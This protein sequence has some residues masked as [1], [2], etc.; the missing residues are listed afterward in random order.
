MYLIDTIPI[1][2]GVAQDT[3][4][5]FSSKPFQTGTLINAPLRSR[6]IKALVINASEAAS[7]KSALRSANHSLKKLESQRS[8]RLLSAD[9]IRAT[10]ATAEYF[11]CSPGAAMFRLIP[12]SALSQVDLLTRLRYPTRVDVSGQSDITKHSI[13]GLIH[14]PLEERY[15]L[16]RT[17]I[18]EEFVKGRSVLVVAPSIHEAA[19]L[20]AN[21][22]KGIERYTV[23]LNGSMPRTGFVSAWRQAL[24]TDHATLLI[25]T[26]AVA[27]IPRAD[28]TLTILESEADRAW[29]QPGRPHIDLRIFLELLTRERGANMILG[30]TMVRPETYYRWNEGRLIEAAKPRF[31][32]LAPGETR[33]EDMRVSLQADNQRFEV[34]GGRLRDTIATAGASSERTVLFASRRGLAPTTVCRDCGDAVV[35]GRCSAPVVL[36]EGREGHRR[37]FLCHKCG[38]VMNARRTCTRCGNWQLVTLGIGADLVEKEAARLYPDRPL[39]SLTA[40]TANTDKRAHDITTRFAASSGGIMIC[41]EMALRYLSRIDPAPERVAVVSVDSL[42]ALPDFRAG[43]RVFA[44]VLALRSLASKTFILQTRRP[45][46][47]VLAQAVAGDILGLYRNEL[48]IRKTLRYPPFAALI[49]LQMSGKEDAVRGEMNSLEKF[50]A[51]YNPIIYPGFTKVVRGKFVMN[52]LVKL[53]PDAWPKSDLIAKLRSLPPYIEVEIDPESVL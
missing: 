49:K 20:Y 52:A 32:L 48:T 4:T 35:C 13:P 27:A 22:S 24:V 9:F 1:S 44:I 16:Y 51:E 41:T 26:A 53:E 45:E 47:R 3:L 43:E 7:A 5:Y 34:I 46:D 42:L 23:L 50:L 12:L 18:R 11:T 15:A 6:K 37:F 39:F 31:R 38:S 14:A 29:R 21:L 40:D 8:S 2:R 10:L 36:H 33:I 25:G 28:I 17:K 19:A 30:G